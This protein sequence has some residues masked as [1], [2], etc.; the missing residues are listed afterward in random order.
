MATFLGS[1]FSRSVEFW[2]LFVVLL[3]NKI[4]TNTLR[5][6]RQGISEKISAVLLAMLLRLM[7][8]VMR[9]NEKSASVFVKQIWLVLVLRLI[10]VYLNNTNIMNKF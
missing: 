7:V 5:N 3:E 4:V 1:T 10:T 6:L 2:F 9:C 8:N